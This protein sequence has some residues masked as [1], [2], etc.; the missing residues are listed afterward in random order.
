MRRALLPILAAAACATPSVGREVGLPPG[1]VVT[2]RAQVRLELVSVRWHD[3]GLVARVRID[4]AGAAPLSIERRGILL[5]YG[6]LEFP[7]VDDRQFAR[8]P[9][10]LVVAAGARRDLA[11]PF[12]IGGRIGAGA[13][14][15][16]RLRALRRGAQW[17]EPLG[18]EV[19]S[20]PVP[21]DHG[22]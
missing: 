6:G 15:T 14:S 22:A 10:L 20:P 1:E 16:L 5:D 17:I 7:V 13:V 2:G 9:A 4:N 8:V 21:A 11:L 19:P 18:L 12:S 3:R